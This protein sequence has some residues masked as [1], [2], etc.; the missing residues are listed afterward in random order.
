VPF[1]IS[2]FE[3]IAYGSLENGVDVFCVLFVHLKVG[4]SDSNAVANS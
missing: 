2:N 1:A 4:A 3:D